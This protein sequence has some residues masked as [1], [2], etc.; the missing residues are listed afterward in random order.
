MQMEQ[1]I[2]H[3]LARADEVDTAINV[4][5][6]G[7][8]ARCHKLET[9][10][11]LELG[12]VQKALHVL[13][14]RMDHAVAE[15]ERRARAT[16]EAAEQRKRAGED[17]IE[18]CQKASDTAIAALRAELHQVR[19]EMLAA[20][21]TGRTRQTDSKEV[22]EVKVVNHYGDDS[23]GDTFGL[24]TSRHQAAVQAELQAN[25]ALRIV[26]ST[27]A[28]NSGHCLSLTTVLATL[29]TS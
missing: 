16:E 3:A 24:V 5:D 2:G 22:P 10:V 19:T 25:P 1:L 17:A 8:K 9:E 27:S 28:L 15:V 23:T 4:L 21:D 11:K 26:S 12:A 6:E 13:E 18:R 29:H 7:V 14:Q 20:R